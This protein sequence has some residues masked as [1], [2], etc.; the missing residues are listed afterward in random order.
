MGVVVKHYGKTLLELQY[1]LDLSQVGTCATCHAATFHGTKQFA[2]ERVAMHRAISRD[3][4]GSI[5][6]LLRHI[7]MYDAW[8]EEAHDKVVRLTPE[9]LL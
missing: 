6:E 2:N 4:R 1:K 9:E 3:V 8:V 7:D 5:A